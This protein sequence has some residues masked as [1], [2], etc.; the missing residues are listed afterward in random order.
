MTGD[1]GIISGISISH[2]NATLDQLETATGADQSELV[3]TLCAE[4][5]ISEAFVL[6]T[7]NRVEAYVVAE[8]A[9]EGSAVLIDFLD[10]VSE[11][12]IR[13]FG[14]EAS[15]K[16]LL[17]VAGGLE[18][19][20]I[21]EDQILGQ[22]REA[23]EAARHAGGMGPI[24]GEG[25]RKSLRVGERA[26]AETAINE[27]VVSLASAAVRLA[28]EKH[29]L[30]GTTAVVVG[31]G[32]MGQLAAKH[33]DGSVEELVLANR[34]VR[35]AESV[36]QSVSDPESVE[37]AGIDDLQGIF[38]RGDVIISATGS[39]EVIISRAELEEIGDSFIVDI[40]RPRDIPPAA[41]ECPNLTVY[42]LDSLESVTDKTRQMR[43]EAALEVEAI[44][45]EEYE[46]LLTQYK[47]KRADQ[48]ISAMYEGAERIK[49]RE[50]EE[51]FEKLNLD[52]E[53]EEVVQS[54]ADSL[55][56]QLLAPP[57]NSLRDAAEADD[58][59][60]IHTALRLFNPEL[61]AELD[62]ELYPSLDGERDE[63]QHRSLEDESRPSLEGQG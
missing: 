57:T 2:E 25:V 34:T 20:V 13:E 11:E 49:T 61:E 36:A 60:T 30:Q 21:G 32:E 58:W 51:M 41:E 17:R 18:S 44:V 39:D 53:S 54:M 27:G 59:T 48:V 45:E 3:R 56:S 7:C 26:R 4:A 14:H 12:V 62:E 1:G 40:T 22:I 8:T 31:A 28:A 24:L 52:N 50:L 47:R 9:E 42:D 35:R 16:H 15:L 23:Y 37:T 55:V 43:R 33:L 63:D 5:G 46:R 19:L 10:S 29:G 6:Q 38:S